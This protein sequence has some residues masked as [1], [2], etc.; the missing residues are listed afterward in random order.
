M[1]VYFSSLDELQRFTPSLRMLSH[2]NACLH[3]K[4]DDQWV[5]H[6]VVYNRH[7]QVTGKRIVCSSRYGRMGCGRTRQLYLK[8]Y[9][10]RRW[11]DLETVVAFIC[12][13]LKGV[14]A[15]DAYR[16]A[17]GNQ[18]H[19]ARQGWRWLNSLYAQLGRFRSFL[20]GVVRETAQ[21]PPK[22][23]T[24]MKVLLPTLEAIVRHLDGRISPHPVLQP[25]FF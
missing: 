14:S 11:Y 4:Q 24:R 20:I 12:S 17:I 10:P 16:Y 18:D 21:A 19:D 5:S 7:R 13:L 1:Q 15:A 22:S 8:R 2:E 25:R 6:G 23:A 3:C 9:I